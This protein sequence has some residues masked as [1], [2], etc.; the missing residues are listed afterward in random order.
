MENCVK[1]ANVQM[2]KFVKFRN[3]IARMLGLDPTNMHVPDYEI[4]SK[5]ER[6]IQKNG[7]ESSRNAPYHPME[8]P[9][10]AVKT[11]ISIDLPTRKKS[12]R[13]A[14]TRR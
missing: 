11:Q 4:V 8:N 13:G 6:L 5:L 3:M 1:D 7:L 10:R 12:V 9:Y 2:D 14:K